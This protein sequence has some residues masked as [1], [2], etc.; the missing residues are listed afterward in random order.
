MKSWYLLVALGLASCSTVATDQYIGMTSRAIEC[1]R[2]EIEIA[3]EKHTLWVGES[4]EWEAMCRGT[5][6][7]CIFSHG[8]TECIKNQA[9]PPADTPGQ[10]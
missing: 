1:P 9:E 7:H 8:D 6:Y 5:Q 4:I 2:E 10:P 3:D